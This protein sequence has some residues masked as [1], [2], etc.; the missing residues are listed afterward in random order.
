MLTFSCLR[1]VIYFIV[2]L[3]LSF[4]GVLE[5]NEDVIDELS[6]HNDKQIIEFELYVFVWVVFAASVLTV[7]F[8]GER[9]VTVLMAECETML[10]YL[11]KK[12][13]QLQ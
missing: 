11:W 8:T 5:P 9:Y 1:V 4:R 3:L 6:G 12:T 13:K 7:A 2:D 10:T